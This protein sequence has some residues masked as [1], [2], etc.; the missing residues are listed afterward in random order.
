MSQGGAGWPAWL[1]TCQLGTGRST[2]DRVQAWGA[3]SIVDRGWCVAAEG[4][5]GR[6]GAMAARLRLAVTALWCMGG[7]SEGT[8][9][10]VLAKRARCA[11]LRGQVVAGKA[12]A[13]GGAARQRPHYSGE[14]ARAT[15]RGRMTGKGTGGFLTTQRSSGNRPRR[16]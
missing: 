11:R 6:G 3:R 12:G 16:R 1:A 7:C 15:E 10:L 13:R 5:P 9:V 8:I 4:G 14:G 2:V